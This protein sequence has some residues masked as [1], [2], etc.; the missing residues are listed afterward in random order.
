MVISVWES[1][2]IPVHSYVQKSIKYGVI[3]GTGINLPDRAR[4]FY[5]ATISKWEKM[6][7][8]GSILLSGLVLFMVLRFDQVVAVISS[9]IR[10]VMPL[11]TGIVIAY[12]LNLIVKVF[13]R[14]YFPKTRKYWLVKMKKPAC[15]I[16]ACLF[17]LVIFIAIITLIVPQIIEI[18][19][20]LGS[21]IPIL[22]EKLFLFGNQTL[23]SFPDI[24]KTF[25][26]LPDDID[27]KMIDALTSMTG[28]ALNVAGF[29]I[30]SVIGLLIS[31]IF[32][33]YLLF[34]RDILL[35]QANKFFNIYLSEC[36]RARLYSVFSV[37]NSVFSKFVVGQAIES[38]ILGTMCTIG[39][40]IL[41]FPYA[42]TIGTVVGVTAL[43][44]M[45]G[46]YIGGVIGFLIILAENTYQAIGFV[47]FL[48]ILQQFEGSVI[49]PRVVGASVGLPGIF[50]FAAVVTGGG[51]FG[52][53][54]VLFA[55]PITATIY[56]LVQDDMRSR[57]AG[58]KI[59]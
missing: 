6:K 24:F 16:L 52:I 40:L 42:G 57:I 21:Q 14:H 44:P 27:Q 41:R 22:Y 19:K 23:S 2:S 20:I 25:P 43:I 38:V 45:V 3:V 50:V 39:M 33:L 12:I 29:A 54:G 9:V 11:F 56:K 47:V 30:G 1:Y 51:L 5:M 58:S 18:M 28:G 48:I 36:K 8:T 37:A 17:V 31:T 55:V 53:P 4:R 10:I 13:E 34:S 46:A 49:Y 26:K 59:E 7:T 32:A 35:L 15:V